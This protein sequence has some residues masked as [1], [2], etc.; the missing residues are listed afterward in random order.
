MNIQQL[1]DQAKGHDT[2]KIVLDDYGLS[3]SLRKPPTDKVERWTRRYIT[4]SMTMRGD[5]D[6]E[7]EGRLSADFYSFAL[8]LIPYVTGWDGPEDEFNDRKLL[9]FFQAYPAI[10]GLFAQGFRGVWDEMQ[11]GALKKK[12][13]LKPIS[14][15]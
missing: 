13:S 2:L 7:Q 9:E 12:E 3:F 14:D 15:G 6:A 5:H 10:A 4:L 8:E 11:A 1:I